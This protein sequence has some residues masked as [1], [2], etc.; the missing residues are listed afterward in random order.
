MPCPEHDFS[1]RRLSMGLVAESQI[2][3]VLAVL[4]FVLMATVTGGVVYLTAAEW[5]DRRRR[6]RDQ[7]GASK[8][9]RRSRKS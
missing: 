9:A 8:G 4:A 6:G 1:G 7:Q 3:T 2:Y 5:R